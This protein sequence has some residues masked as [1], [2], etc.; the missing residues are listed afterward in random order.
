MSPVWVGK[1]LVGY[2]DGTAAMS[3]ASASGSTQPNAHAGAVHLYLAGSLNVSKTPNAM[4][5]ASQLP[6]Q[7]SVVGWG[8]TSSRMCP[9]MPMRNAIQILGI[10]WPTAAPATR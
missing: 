6:I 1:S 3:S 4:I 8:A 10:L 2:R 5:N 9:T 7:A